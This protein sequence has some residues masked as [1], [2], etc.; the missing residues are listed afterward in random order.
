VIKICGVIVLLAVI[1]LGCIDAPVVVEK[2]YQDTLDWV[3]YNYTDPVTGHI[4]PSCDMSPKRC[5]CLKSR[6][7]VM[8]I[9]IREISGCD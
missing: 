5:T 8:G 9:P 3:N 2:T 6:L 4:K 7:T 1:F